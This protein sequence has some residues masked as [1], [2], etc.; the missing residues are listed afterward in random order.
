MIVIAAFVGGGLGGCTGTISSPA[1]GAG[2]GAQPAGGAG[3]S[4][5]TGPG[6]VSS[7]P[8]GTTMTTSAACAAAPLAHSGAYLRRLTAWEYV[9]TVTD[10][11]DV[12]STVDLVDAL[13]ADIRANGFSNDSGGQLVSLD[14]ASGYSAAADAVGAALAKAPTWIASFATCADTS[15]TCRDAVVGALG[16][17]LFRRPPTDAE[18]KTFGAL[19]DTA[20]ANGATTTAAASAVVVRAMLQVPQFLYRLEDQ[21]PPS[22][23]A[24]ARPLG[25]YELATRLSYLLWSSAPDMALLSSAQSGAL[26]ATDGKELKSQITRM[27]AA[28]RARG[29]VQRYFREWLSLDDLDDANRGATFTPQ[30]STDMKQETM[31]D[32][33]DQLWDQ[34]Q[35]LLSML[36]TKTTKVTP[37]LA[38]YYG[39]GAPDAMGRYATDGQPG[40]EGFLTHAGVLTVNGDANASI[41]LR[42]LYML[43]TVLCQDVPAPPP[44]AT[45]V[46]LAPATASQRVQSDARLMNNPCMSCHGIFDP[47][48]YAFEPFDSMGALQMKDINGNA[49]R[50][51]GWITNAGMANV[52]YTDVPS[53]MTA[54]AADTRVT[55]CFATKAAQ[56]ALGRGMDAGDACML[57]DIRA[58]ASAAHGTGQAQAQ[59]FA[60][61]VSAVATSPYFGYTAVN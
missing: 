6:T 41:V 15:A 17:R 3:A 58:R 22:A 33:A 25:G 61:L 5:A 55:D 43:R 60:D 59:T 48:A 49:V 50:Q 29:M 36:T 26:V 23:G 34:A 31:D 1:P 53:Y 21:T 35:P 45:S 56:F 10:I 30:L 4:G 16:L 37:A 46:V 20:V 7:L 40:R 18:V 44:G 19:F 42:G 27:L 12:P 11:L 28:P 2:P 51:D 38:K 9:N 52:D 8:P 24:V 54:L 14:H 39:Y 47:L 32:A 13:P 57:E